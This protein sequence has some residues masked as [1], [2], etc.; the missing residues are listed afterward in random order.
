MTNRIARRKS[1]NAEK[2]STHECYRQ[3]TVRESETRTIS[4]HT[5][6]NYHFVIGVAQNYNVSMCKCDNC[7]GK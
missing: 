7:N 3:H 5:V 2:N 1:V 4:S 6:S